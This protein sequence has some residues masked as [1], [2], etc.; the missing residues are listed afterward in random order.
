MPKYLISD[1][2]NPYIRQGAWVK[3]F[4]VLFQTLE[5]IPVGAPQD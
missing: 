3:T 5:E 4:S 2:S 1:L